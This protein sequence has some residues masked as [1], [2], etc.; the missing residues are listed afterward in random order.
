[1]NKKRKRNRF[2]KIN[3]LETS[4]VGIPAYPDAHMSFI[5]ALSDYI[6]K[7]ERRFELNNMS[8]T[9]NTVAEETVEQVTET[10]E[11]EE[12]VEAPVE[13]SVKEEATQEATEE[14]EETE[15]S[16]SVEDRLVTLLSKAVEEAIEK[17]SVKRGLI[18]SSDDKSE[19]LAKELQNLSVGELAIK[20]GWF[21][22]F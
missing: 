18:E 11:V 7:D 5:K 6:N 3:L 16:A 8:E 13:E 1:M 12:T 14:V 4:A 10:Q 22:K 19:A 9:E 21:R 17:S 20:S 15:K 2:M